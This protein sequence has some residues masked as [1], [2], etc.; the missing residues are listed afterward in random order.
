MNILPYSYR[1]TVMKGQPFMQVSK[2]MLAQ[3]DI[4]FMFSL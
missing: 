4:K 3:I 2:K 1:L